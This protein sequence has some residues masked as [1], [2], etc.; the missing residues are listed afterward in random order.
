MWDLSKT[1]E[2][3]LLYDLYSK[4][5]TPKQQK[6]F[7]LYLMENFSLQEIANEL[8]VSRSAVHDAISKII[9]ILNVYEEKMQLLVKDIRRKTLYAYYENETEA[10]VGMLI[11]ELRKID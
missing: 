2:L 9:N 4:L 10:N 3:N 7:S 11:A 8:N 1:N 5:L 6:Y